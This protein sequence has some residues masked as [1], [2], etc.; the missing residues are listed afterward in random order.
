L[1]ISVTFLIN[2]LPTQIC[3]RILRNQYDDARSIKES[4]DISINSEYVQGLR[5]FLGYQDYNHFVKETIVKTNNRFVS[6]VRSH[7]LILLIC[8]I[9]ITSTIGI[10]NFNKQRLMIWDNDRYIEVHFNEETYSLKKLK[11]YNKDRVKNFYKKT[12]L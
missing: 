4:E 8:S 6:Y 10:V 11:L 3:G 2:G 1:P 12:N 7:W 9:T 5:K